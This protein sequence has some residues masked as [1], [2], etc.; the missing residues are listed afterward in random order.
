MGYFRLL[1]EVT[2]LGFGS[3]GL[4]DWLPA[5]SLGSRVLLVGFFVAVVLGM[6]CLTLVCS[7]GLGGVR[8]WVG[9]VFCSGVGLV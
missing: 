6:V 1:R 7:F 4:V 9:W 5:D 8:F 3:G 2:S